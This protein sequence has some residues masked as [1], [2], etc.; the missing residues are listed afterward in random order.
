MR[1]KEENTEDVTKSATKLGSLARAES[2]ADS[3][4]ALMPSTGAD[5]LKNIYN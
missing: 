5:V 3:Q 4:K 2:W 1:R